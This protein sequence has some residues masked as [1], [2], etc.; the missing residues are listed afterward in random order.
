MDVVY[1]YC[2]SGYGG[3]RTE[4]DPD[5]YLQLGR[6]VKFKPLDIDLWADTDTWPLD[7]WQ[8][9]H[10]FV[11]LNG[12]HTAEV[13]TGTLSSFVT[14]FTRT[15]GASGVLG[16]E[17]ALEQ[18]VASWAMELFLGEL[19]QGAPVGSA[20]RNTRWAMLGRGNLMG[21]AYTPYCLSQLSLRSPA[22]EEA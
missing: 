10:P 15:A 16:T 5:P 8:N 22:M 11:V 1:L 12:C 6:R 19:A 7:H 3:S 18:G 9:R 20:L 2:H 21:L 14:E 17:I 4:A 13:E